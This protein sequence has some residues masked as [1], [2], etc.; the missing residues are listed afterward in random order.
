MR[1]SLTTQQAELEREVHAYLADLMTPALADE[2][3]SLPEGGGEAEAPEYNQALRRLGQDGWLGIGWPKEYGGQGRTH[4]EQY[5]FFNAVVGWYRIP[6]PMLT[7]NTVGPTLMAVGSEAQKEEFLPKILRGE[8][9]VAIGYTEPSS[10]SDLASLRTT[11][12]RDGDE[13]VIN[14]QKVFT[15][16]AHFSDYIWLA[17]RTDPNAPKHKGISVF[18]VKRDSPGIRVTPIHCMGNFRTNMTFYEDVRVPASSLVGEENRGWQY[19]N[20]QLAMERVTLVPHSRTHRTLE[21]V[22]AWASAHS[23]DGQRLIDKPWV[24]TTLAKLLAEVE[25][26]RLFNYRVAWQL[27]RGEVPFAESFMTKVY[28]SELLQRVHGFAL[29]VASLLGLLEPGAEGPAPQRGRFAR[30]FVSEALM[31]FGGG[32]N[33]VLRDAI[34]VAALGLPR[35]R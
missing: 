12:R 32:A 8:L 6:I 11:A 25:V 14:G 22:A 34:A 24:R 18:L 16:L 7:L 15:S 2:L 28:G 1:F 23:I 20:Q 9:Q 4:V 33:E 10:G 27:T 35:S 5:I 30:S 3:V 29:Q 19:M 13:Y 26:L 21:E 17:A 31:T